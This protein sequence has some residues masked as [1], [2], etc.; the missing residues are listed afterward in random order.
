M[1]WAKA[2]FEFRGLRAGC[3]CGRFCSSVTG[4]YTF[5]SLDPGGAG[6]DLPK[7]SMP[8]LSAFDG[9]RAGAAFADSRRFVSR[10]K[11]AL[12]DDQALQGKVVLEL[13]MAPGGR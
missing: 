11:C 3:P 1:R 9:K 12:R 7:S 2:G 4:S 5:G 6:K 8:T 10:W 13:K